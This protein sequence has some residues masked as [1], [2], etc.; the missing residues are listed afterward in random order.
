VSTVVLG[1]AAVE[2]AAVAAERFRDLSESGAQLRFVEE[3]PRR[4]RVE[5]RRSPGA[6]PPAFEIHGLRGEWLT[7]FFPDGASGPVRGWSARAWTGPGA[8]RALRATDVF[9]GLEVEVDIRRDRELV[10][11]L[12]PGGLSGLATGYTLAQ[13]EAYLA[14][15]PVDP[16]LTLTQLGTSVQ[17]RAINKVV[18]DDPGGGLPPSR[19][20]TMVVLIRQHGDEWASSFVFEGMLDFLLGLRATEPERE[21]TRTTRW[22]FYPLVNPDGVVLDQR[23]N[24]NGVDLNRDW[25]ATGPAVDQEPEIFLV[26]TDVGSLPVGQPRSAGDHHGWSAGVDGGFHNSDGG[27][28]VGATHPDYLEGLADTMFYTAYEPAV[29]DWSANG[30]QDGMSRV[31]LYHWLDWV[32]H[33]P[34]YDGGPRDEETLRLTGERYIQSMYDALH[35]VTFVDSV[36][37]LERRIDLGDDVFVEVDDLD[38]NRD[39][40]TVE[41]TT[42]AL[43]DRTTGDRETL[44]LTE[45][46]ADD[47][48][49]VLAAPL[50]TEAGAVV[51]QDGIL[52]TAPGA[53]ITAQ[54]VDADRP[55]DNS[56]ALLR[57]RQ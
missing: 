42:V 23:W 36:G 35:G 46:G 56:L 4:L 50:P 30:G 43:R 28:P 22:I 34:E 24:A 9:G 52:Q 41:T 17:G 3:S 26:Q 39:P 16:R 45:T 12:P 57:V 11:L 54:Y 48:L 32:V 13:Y 8:W 18:F 6:E 33:T 2:P 1:T 19:K 25:R 10:E 47:G 21:I 5:L 20:R 14:G 37:G 15:L 38:E 7:L 53:L 55:L 31:E 40:L 29:F 51:P 44:L 49:F 27:L